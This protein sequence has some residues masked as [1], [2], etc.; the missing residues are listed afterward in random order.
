MFSFFFNNFSCLGNCNKEK[1]ALFQTKLWSLRIS[2]Y[3]LTYLKP[4]ERERERKKRERGRI[5]QFKDHFLYLFIRPFKC[6]N[7]VILLYVN[8]QQEF[9]RLPSLCLKSFVFFFSCYS[10]HI[11]PFYIPYLVLQK[12]YFLFCFSYTSRKSRRKSKRKKKTKKKRKEAQRCFMLIRA[13]TFVAINNYLNMHPRG[14]NSYHFT[15]FTK[16]VIDVFCH[17]ATL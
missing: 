7:Q 12:I 13:D 17:K 15:L 11:V 1:K 10:S 5:I 2:K 14:Y 9:I 16:Q 6:V 3:F 4:L 8:K